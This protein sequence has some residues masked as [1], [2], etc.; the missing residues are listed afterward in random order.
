MCLIAVDWASSVCLSFGGHPVVACQQTL[1][2]LHSAGLAA[3]CSSALV[4]GLLLFSL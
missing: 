2:C 3:V 1:V 4:P